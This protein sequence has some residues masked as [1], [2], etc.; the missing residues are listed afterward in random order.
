MG[1]AFV[2]TECII[3][4]DWAL[5]LEAIDSGIICVKQIPWQWNGSS[6]N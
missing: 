4:G 1:Q 2:E 3:K 6:K 5:L